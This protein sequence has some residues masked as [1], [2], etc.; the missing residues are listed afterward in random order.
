LKYKIPTFVAYRKHTGKDKHRL[1]VKGW[2]KI[3]QANA[4]E[5][6][7]EQLYSYDKANFKPK[8]KTKK[9]TSY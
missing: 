9:V 6:K 4:G 7:Q 5:S 3:F 2:K 8:E 1:Q